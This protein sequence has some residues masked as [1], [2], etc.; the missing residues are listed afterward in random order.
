M[1]LN[2]LDLNLLRIFDAVMGERSV[3]RAGLRLGLSQA[4]VSNALNRLRAAFEDELFLRGPAGME[5]TALARELAEPIRAALGNVAAALA[6]RL[7]FD[8]A[9][10][11]HTFLL[12]MSDHAEFVL[13]PPLICRLRR[14]APGTSVTIRHADRQDA[15]DLL[16]LDKIELAVGVLPDPPP[17]MVRQ[18][19]FREPLVV[20]MAAH[21]PAADGA[22]FELETYLA[23]PH[24]LISAT[25]T[26]EGAIDRL[27]AAMGRQRRLAAVASHLLA[28]PPML[29]G[30]DLF[31]TMLERVARPLAT[32]FGLAVRPLPLECEPART[33]M[34]WH[35]RH[36]QRPAHVWL[37]RL[38]AE[39]AGLPV[40]PGR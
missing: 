34:I 37:R 38:V 16:D 35:R 20:L 13:G 27:L 9:A 30:T 4:A 19:L 15:L 39:L 1:N 26:R 2:Q 21:H 17:R 28:A 14:D 31:C 11:D 6:L 25:A 40:A 32:A 10:S 29:L 23:H 7:P 22:R 5:P 36:D 33:G 12:G 18:I 8:P 24:L 3:T